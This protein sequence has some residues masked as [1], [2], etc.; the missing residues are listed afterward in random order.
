MRT[1]RTL[2]TLRT[3]WLLPL[4]ALVHLK[5]LVGIREDGSRRLGL[6]AGFGIHA[7]LRTGLSFRHLSTRGRRCTDPIGDT[8]K[9]HQRTERDRE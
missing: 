5:F 1:V 6:L 3:K 4:A 7:A 9:Q 8:G 2:R